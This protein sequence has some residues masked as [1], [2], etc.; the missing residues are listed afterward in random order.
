MSDEDAERR[1]KFR[2]VLKAMKSP[3]NRLDIPEKDHNNQGFQGM[4]ERFGR[5]GSERSEEKSEMAKKQ[6]IGEGGRGSQ[7]NQQTSKNFDYLYQKLNWVHF[8][9]QRD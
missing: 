6:G 4:V 8:C 3:V 5:S 9:G 1:N 7:L 2:E